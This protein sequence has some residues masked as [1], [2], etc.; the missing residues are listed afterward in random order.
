MSERK[1]I[2]AIVTTWFPGSHA[3][4]IASKFATGFPTADGLVAPEVDLV[5]L[6]MDQVHPSDIGIEFA[7]RHGVAIY[8]SIRGAITLAA[9]PAD[10]WPTACDW[11]DGELA[12]D[13]VLIIAEHGDYAMNDRR[14]RLYPRRHFFE[15]VCAVF[16]NSGR[17]APVFTDKHLSYSWADAMWMHQRA[18]D[19]EAPMMAGSSLPVAGREPE[20]EHTLGA[21]IDE[22]VGVQASWTHEG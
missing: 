17:S 4:L 5:S 22:A 16:A 8:P 19:L 20:F 11:Q 10:H 6:Y 21:Q 9:P 15:Q 1:K 12:V 18:R 7:R 3:D 13:G 2:A 14:Q